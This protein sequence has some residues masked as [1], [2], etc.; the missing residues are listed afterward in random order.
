MNRSTKRFLYKVWVVFRPSHWLKL[1]DIDPEWDNRL[2]D[3]LE[4]EPI[5]FVGKYEALIGDTPVWIANHPYASGTSKASLHGDD[6]LA[7]HRGV[8]ELNCS[9]ATALLLG[10]KL[11]H[12]RITA[13]LYHP[14]TTHLWLDGG[15]ILS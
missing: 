14:N 8:D 4:N 5:K 7:S 3:L 10:R 9:R 15:V 6:S 13:L 1:G 11:K 12:G 2:W